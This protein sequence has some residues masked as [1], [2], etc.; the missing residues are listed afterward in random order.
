MKKKSSGDPFWEKT[1]ADY[2]TG[3]ALGLFEDATPEQ[4]NLNSI[5]L[6]SSLGEERFGGPN[7]N[8][9]KEYFNGKILLNQLIL[10]HQVQYLL[11]MKQSK[12]LLQHLNKNKTFL[13]KRKLIR[14]VII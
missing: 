9:I 1:A 5:N 4:V 10:M 12:V 13:I 8:Y 2:F 14:N 7:N 6:M 3:L 11:Q